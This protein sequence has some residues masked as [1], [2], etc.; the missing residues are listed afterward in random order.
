VKS[1]LIQPVP[2]KAQ[3]PSSGKA[4]MIA[5][6]MAGFLVVFAGI[7]PRITRYH[8]SVAVAKTAETTLPAVSVTAAKTSGSVAEVVLPGSTE[9]LNVAAIDARATGYVR[10]RLVDIGSTVKAGQVL[11]VIESPEL[12]QEVEQ[13]QAAVQQTQAARE[14]VRSN[15]EQARAGV[16]QARAN[17]AQLGAN[18]QIAATT[19]QRWTKLVDKGVLPKQSGDERR[20]AF[21]AS[22]AATEAGRAALDTAEANVASRTADLAAA[23]AT[24]A[25]QNANLRRVERLQAFERV[26]APFNGVVTQRKVEKGDLVTA[27]S[28]ALFTVVEPN[29]LRIQVNVPQSY[30]V[31]LNVGQKAEVLIPERPG[32]KYA[33]TVARTAKALESSSRTL[34]TEVQVDNKNGDLLPGMYAQV[35][36]DIPRREPIAVIPADAL[37]ADAKGTRVAVVDSGNCVH[38]RDVQVGRDLGPEVEVLSGIHAGENVVSNAPD[39]L[40]EGAEIRRIAGGAK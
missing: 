14:Q 7:L 37:I 33:G 23:D 5:V 30:A 29:T 34:L 2:E 16:N 12:D 17:L 28:G 27:G 26:E 11:A 36:F 38:F 9:A 25:A 6:L 40:E 19:D 31:D 21:Q 22:H 32:K 20:S 13:A 35:K 15:L 4:R 10:E 3:R 18:E 24:V 8:E 39:T 1:T